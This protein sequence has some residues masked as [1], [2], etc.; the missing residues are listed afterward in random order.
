M[1]RREHRLAEAASV[2]ERLRRI[3]VRV[4]SIL[5]A[6]PELDAGAVHFF[7]HRIDAS[8]RDVDRFLDEHVQPLACRSDT[9]FR[10]ASRGA[11]DDHEIQA[12]RQEPS[13]V[14]VRSRA[15][16]CRERGRPCGVGAEDGVD[17]QP[18][19][20]LCGARVGVAD[21]SAADDSNSHFGYE[22]VK[23]RYC[24]STASAGTWPLRIRMRWRNSIDLPGSIVTLSSF[25]PSVKTFSPIGFAAKRP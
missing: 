2:D 4:Q 25:L 18:L 5:K 11:A 10:V 1:P 24:R 22:P 8:G 9:L 19:D 7:E 17:R 20:G 12:V 13:E 21:V 3:D 6:H 16:C 23:A 14:V 15:D